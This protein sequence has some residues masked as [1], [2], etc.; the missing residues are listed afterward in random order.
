MKDNGHQEA[1][2]E[3]FQTMFFGWY[4]L[5]FSVQNIGVD[6]RAFLPLHSYSCIKDFLY[7]NDVD[8]AYFKNVE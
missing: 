2:P 4:I 8:I 6:L 5:W 7:I 3:N 1:Y